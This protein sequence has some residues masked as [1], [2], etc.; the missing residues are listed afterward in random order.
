MGLNIPRVLSVTIDMIRG[1]FFRLL[2]LWLLFVIF[3]LAGL[4]LV[5]AFTGVSAMV[6]GM[7]DSAAGMGGLGAATIAVM[8]IFYVAYFYIYAAQS[9]SMSAAASPL[10]QPEFGITLSRGFRG[11]LSLL[12]VYILLMIGYLIVSVAL[13]LLV[14]I[15]AFLG[16]AGTILGVI[17]L[18]PALLYL[19]CRLSLLAPV[20]AV[21]GVSNPVGVIART[22]QLTAGNAFK[23][24][25]A[26][27]V[28]SLFAIVLVG[29][30]LAVF[31]GSFSDMTVTET[32]SNPAVIVSL[33]LVFVFVM[34][35]LSVAG[36]AL[37]SVLHSELTDSDTARLGRTFE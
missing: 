24:F 13:G 4:M 10:L 21:D 36:S 34:I 15:L 1:R 22:W 9:V 7:T 12:C 27:V 31:W 25:I 20:I 8:V 26:L 28:Y 6:G 32:M 14:G 17:I 33:T 11:G 19:A 16:D 3:Q 23:I 29:M 30:I 35:V 37:F 2:A 18:L 5:G